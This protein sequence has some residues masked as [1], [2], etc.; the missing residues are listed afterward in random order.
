MKVMVL[1]VW[2]SDSDGVKRKKKYMQFNEKHDLKIP[3]TFALGDQFADVYSFKRA[4]KTF[5]V[6]NGFDYYYK[7][8]DMS[9]VSVVCREHSK[10]NCKWKIHASID[11]TRTCLQI[12]TLY[13]TYTCG[14]RYEN[15]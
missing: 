15:T 3:V 14:N 4:L 12:K 10:K 1:Q 7:H 2:N 9:R 13:P 5:A 6:Q 8:N 11:V